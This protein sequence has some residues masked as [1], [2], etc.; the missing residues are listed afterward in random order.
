VENRFGTVPY[1]AELN[2]IPMIMHRQM[3]ACAF[4][5]MVIDHFERD[6]ESV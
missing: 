1:P 5:D 6:A 2:D 3:D 4:A